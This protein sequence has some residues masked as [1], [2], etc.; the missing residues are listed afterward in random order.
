MPHL[1]E[2]TFRDETLHLRHYLGSFHVIDESGYKRQ[3]PDCQA[4]PSRYNTP[5]TA[6]RGGKQRV[7][8]VMLRLSPLRRMEEV[9]ERVSDGFLVLVTARESL[10][11]GF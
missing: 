1:G 4:L 8:R 6:V 7:W 3:P 2:S 5:Q 10:G 9:P 11:N